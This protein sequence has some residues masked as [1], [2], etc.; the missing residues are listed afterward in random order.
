MP[1]IFSKAAQRDLGSELD[2]PQIT[3]L[4]APNGTWN[5]SSVGGTSKNRRISLIRRSRERRKILSIGKLEIKDG[6]TDGF[7]NANSAAT[8]PQVYDKL[9][10]ELKD[11][12]FHFSVSL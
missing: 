9:N 6:K 5:F 11:F 1:L 7:G 10:A 2:E 4:K 12:F 8:K 3:L